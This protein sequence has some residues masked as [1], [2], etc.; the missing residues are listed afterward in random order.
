MRRLAQFADLPPAMRPGYDP[1]RHGAGILHLGPGAFHRAHQADFTDAALAASGGDWRIQAISLHSGRAEAELAPQNGLFTLIERGGAARGIAAI[2]G[3]ASGAAAALQAMAA[4]GCRIVSLTVT[5][6]AYGLDRAT[7][8]C[9]AAHAAVAADLRQPLRPAGVLGVLV[10][11]LALRRAAGMAP[12]AVLC[13]DNLPRNG[14]LLRG[15]VLDFARRIDAGLADWIG[16][17]VA[18]PATMVDRITP[19]P[20][21]AT[22][23]DAAALIGRSDLAAV[24]TEPFRQWVMQDHFPGGRPD[25]AAGGAIFAEDVEAFEAM[26]LR[27]LNGAHSMLAYA[28]F[29]AGHALVRDAMRD[30]A[31]AVLVRRHLAAAAAS[32][33]P[34]PGIDLAAYG[35]DLLRRFENPAMAHGTFQIA[36]D[37]SEKMP[38]RIFAAVARAQELRPF[39]FATAAWLRHVSGR[40]HD[41]AAYVLRDPRAGA[42][43][44]AV[45]G[46]GAEGIFA[47]VAGIVPIPGV[48]RAETVTIL[49]DM[50]QR[51][52]A[53]VLRSEAGG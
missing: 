18:F 23:Q 46:Q 37:G 52:M 50:L 40:C 1:A 31:L 19:A 39:A 28:G 38:Q 7:G 25:W 36:M 4:P 26:K 48:L 10:R 44:R 30:A 17:R 27:M 20:T 11:G 2:A 9:D 53:Q 29:H 43:Q 51:P 21:A 34:V 5:E 32:L 3:A 8:G 47:G 15:A 49:A 42:L 24:E 6:K 33:G 12:F 13:C 35:R 45:Q 22:L 16:A 41:C 14:G